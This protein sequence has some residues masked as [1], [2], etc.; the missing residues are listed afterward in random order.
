MVVLQVEKLCR[1]RALYPSFSS[2]FSSLPD[3]PLQL[4]NM[5]MD[6][7]YGMDPALVRRPGHVAFRGQG[8]QQTDSALRTWILQP[9][10]SGFLS[11]PP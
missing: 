9:G 3:A 4:E 2:L 8:L 1:G 5:G 6:P 11:T 10:L 7:G